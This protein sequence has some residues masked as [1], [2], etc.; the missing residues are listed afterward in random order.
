MATAKETPSAHSFEEL[1][2]KYQKRIE[3]IV[4]WHVRQ[5]GGSMQDG[6]DAQGEILI[7]LYKNYGRLRVSELWAYVNRITANYWTD[8][9]RRRVYAD[10]KS[11]SLDAPLASSKGQRGGTISIDLPDESI[12]IE[13]D[14]VY[15]QAI[16]LP[17]RRAY[18]KALDDMSKNY[19]QAHLLRVKGLS[20]QEIADIQHA[21]VGTVRSRLHRAK[22]LIKRELVNSGLVDSEGNIVEHRDGGLV[23]KRRPLTSPAPKPRP[24]GRPAPT[25]IVSQADREAAQRYAKIMVD[26]GT[27]CPA[28]ALSMIKAE[29]TRLQQDLE[30]AIERRRVLLDPESRQLWQVILESPD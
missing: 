18:N 11:C 28:C 20:Y 25:P 30:L 16:A 17:I 26:M 19:R 7:K 2:Q 29:T 4:Y 22:Y 5:H 21:P 8:Q 1:L 13:H 12:R 23:P 6:E 15:D 3:R 14:V 10:A 27:D 24:V 9:I